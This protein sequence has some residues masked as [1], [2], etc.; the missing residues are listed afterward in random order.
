MSYLDDLKQNTLLHESFYYVPGPD[1]LQKEEIALDTEVPLLGLTEEELLQTYDI[2]FAE[3]GMKDLFESVD[4]EFDEETL[5]EVDTTKLQQHLDFA[6]KHLKRLKSRQGRV[7]TE[8]IKKTQANVDNLQ[9]RLD[10]VKQHGGPVEPKEATPQKIQF[11][12]LLPLL[13][14]LQLCLLPLSLLIVG[15]FLKLAGPVRM[16]QTK[17]NVKPST[18]K[19]LKPLKRKLC[20]LVKPN[21]HNPKIQLNVKLKS[22]KRSQPFKKGVVCR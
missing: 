5:Q 15:S 7:P 20:K 4:L 18:E 3:D 12:V 10:M 6:L 11:Q 8:Q 19:R 22:I 2:L 21:V 14:L 16:L 1:N 9:R 17:T 13:L